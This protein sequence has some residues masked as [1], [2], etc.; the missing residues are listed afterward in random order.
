[1]LYEIGLSLFHC[2][3]YLQYEQEKEICIC[4]FLELLKQV[5]RQKGDNVVLGGHDAVI[6]EEDGGITMVSFVLFKSFFI[7]ND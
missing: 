1:M 7:F 4:Y 6:L 2:S 3:S 5:D